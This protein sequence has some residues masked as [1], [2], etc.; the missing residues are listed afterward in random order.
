VFGVAE[1]WK[2]AISRPHGHVEGSMT[3]APILTNLNN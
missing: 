1:R 3:W 2:L